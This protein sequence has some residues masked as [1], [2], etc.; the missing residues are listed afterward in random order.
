MTRREK[1]I[2]DLLLKRRSIKQIAGELKIS[3]NT[4]RVHLRN[5]YQKNRLYGLPDLI[6]F[7]LSPK[8]KN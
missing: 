1:Q 2:C 5:I 6:I 3:V 7:L 4:I 8:Q